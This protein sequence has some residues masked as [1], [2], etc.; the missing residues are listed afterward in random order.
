[1][2]E[3]LFSFI[4]NNFII[5]PSLVHF[6]FMFLFLISSSAF[7]FQFIVIVCLVACIKA[8]L[9]SALILFNG[10][11]LIFQIS[12]C[13]L[14]WMDQLYD[15]SELECIDHM[16]WMSM[17]SLEEK[18]HE[19]RIMT[20]NASQFVRLIVKE[21]LNRNPVRV[22]SLIVR[23]RLTLSN[24]FCMNLWSMEWMH[25]IGD[26]EGHVLIESSHLAKK[27]TLCMNDLSL[28]PSLSWKYDF[29]IKP[30]ACT[31]YLL[32]PCLRL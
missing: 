21:C 2:T 19:I 11:C 6:M 1:L 7:K 4:L 23:E 22:W 25:E 16:P 24:D 8:W 10:W 3:S 26:D 15:V 14:V 17:Q 27:L 28:A 13:C 20:E 31:V 32:L 9:N 18:E 29:L 30:W 12:V 5:I